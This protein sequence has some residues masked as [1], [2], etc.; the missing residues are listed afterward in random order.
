MDQELTGIAGWA[1]D[2]MESLGGFGA[3]LLIGLENLFPPLP[4]EIIL[5]LAGFTASL[6][7]LGM[8]EMIVW[9]TAGSVIGAWL[10]YGV[11]Y[12]LGRDRT[13][14]IMGAL[15]LVNISDIDKT[16]AWFRKHG[17]WTVLLGRMIPIFRSLIS[18]PAGVTKMKLPIFTALTLV[19]SLIWNTVLISLGYVLGEN[20]TRVEGWVGI[21]SRIVLVAVIVFVIWWIGH[22][23]YTTRKNRKDDTDQVAGTD[24]SEVTDQKTG[25]APATDTAQSSG[26]N[27]AGSTTAGA[28][29]N[30]HPETKAEES[31]S[32]ADGHSGAT[33]SRQQNS[34]EPDPPTTEP[35]E[36]A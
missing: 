34:T 9:C 12:A 6:G 24:Q 16:E 1:V 30:P 36:H 17:T 8:V 28:S 20:W 27:S 10:L 25:G 19:G 32:H 5:P 11:G 2:V 26:A 21:F 18:I 3:F 4:S 35:E 13:R 14:A 22:R 7:T 29:E 23:I 33:D 31:A 15:P